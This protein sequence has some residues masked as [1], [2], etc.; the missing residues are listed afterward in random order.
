MGK[1]I[2]V[3]HIISGLGAGGVEIALYNLIKHSDPERFHHSVISL[4]NLD[5]IG[6]QIRKLG[7]GVSGLQMPKSILAFRK[8]RGFISSIRDFSTDVIQTWMYHAN[9]LGGIA[10]SIIGN[11]PIVWGLHRTYLDPKRDPLATRLIAKLSSPLSYLLP[12]RIISV[13]LAGRESHIRMGYAKDRFVIIPN[14]FDDQ[15]YS[16]DL[17]ARLAIR[18]ELGLKPGIMLIGLGARFHPTKDHLTFLRAVQW[19][20]KSEPDVHFLLCG[21]G[22]SEDNA[23]LMSLIYDKGVERNLH[24]LGQREDMPRIFASLDIATLSSRNEAFPM[25]VGE[26]MACGIP[27]V[28]TD[29]GDTA[30][31]VGDAGVVVPPRDP[32]ALAEGWLSLIELGPEGRLMIG[33]AARQRI[34]ERYSV[35]TMVDRYEHLYREIVCKFS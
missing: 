16:P 33:K 15:R 20:L 31:I 14:G 30:M 24:L 23:G 22:I 17:S 27:C 25:I 7:V 10:G 32:E 3:L 2:R 13:S 5:P 6:A 4:T 29:V 19:L 28:V 26:A 34:K 21:Q 9:F 35:S 1:R 18:E 12:K 8:L 11:V